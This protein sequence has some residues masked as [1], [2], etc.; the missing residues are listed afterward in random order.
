MSTDM[1][2]T[3]VY[4]ETEEDRMVRGKCA[5]KW[6]IVGEHGIVFASYSHIPE[7]LAQKQMRCFVWPEEGEFKNASTWVF[8]DA[9]A[10]NFEPLMVDI[11]TASMLRGVHDALI[12]PANAE[13]MIRM[14]AKSRGHFAKIIQIGWGAMR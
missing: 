13:K 9:H 8:N 4:D 7:I 14:I 12:N 10:G 1:D 3:T 6:K 2:T 5:R 11:V